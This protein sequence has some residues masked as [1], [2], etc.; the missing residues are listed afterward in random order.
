MG[1]KNITFRTAG[2]GLPPIKPSNVIPRYPG[3]LGTFVCVAKKELRNIV[4][5]SFTLSSAHADRMGTISGSQEWHEF[6]PLT[7]YPPVF[8]PG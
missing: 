6:A 4:R 8:A 2:Q 3:H 5:A 1:S 7:D